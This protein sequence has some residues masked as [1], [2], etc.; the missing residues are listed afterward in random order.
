MTKL[1]KQ[2]HLKVFIF[3]YT[4]TSFTTSLCAR[5][6]VKEGKL[7]ATNNTLFYLLSLKQP[8]THATMT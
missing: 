4:S 5:K 6:G 3:N 1:I 2:H 8:H 7:Q